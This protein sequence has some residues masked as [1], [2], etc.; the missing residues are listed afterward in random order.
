MKELIIML[1]FAPILLL[2]FFIGFAIPAQVF[3]L[4]EIETVIK[5][6]AFLPLTI[7]LTWVGVF[8]IITD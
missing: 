5:S 3:G 1:C 4:I 6:I 8:L 2:V 7:V